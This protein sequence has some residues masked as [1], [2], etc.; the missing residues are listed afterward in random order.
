MWMMVLAV[1]LGLA[2]PLWA[3][4]IHLKDGRIVRGEVVSET[5]EVVSVKEPVGTSGYAQARYPTAQIERIER[6]ANDPGGARTAAG[7]AEHSL[8]SKLAMI[9]ARAGYGSQDDLT[10]AR[11]RRLLNQLATKFVEDEQRI[12]EMTANAFQMLGED[13]INESL[14]N[15]M[16]GMNQVFTEHIENQQYAEYIAVYI[17]LR[18]EGQS[19]AGAIN[20]LRG[21]LRAL[22]VR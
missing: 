20:G 14:L 9:D 2:A 7:E 3:D 19:H 6:A 4:T 22:G 11:F 18:R 17:K 16:E 5:D 13:G 1:I 15:L 8:A 12:A 21:F 10:V